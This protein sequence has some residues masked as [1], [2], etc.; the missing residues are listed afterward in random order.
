MRQ[1]YQIVE[2]NRIEKSIR[3][4]ESNKITVFFPNRNALNN[5]TEV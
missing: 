1:F 3:L 5:T 4:R 2:S